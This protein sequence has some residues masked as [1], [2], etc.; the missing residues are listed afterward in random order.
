M[1]IGTRKFL[2]FVLSLGAYM[3]LFLVAIASGNVGKEEL[4]G[5]AFQLGM[6]ISVMSGVFYAGNVIAKKYQGRE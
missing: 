1:R 2:A 4:A 3:I 5:F 6:G